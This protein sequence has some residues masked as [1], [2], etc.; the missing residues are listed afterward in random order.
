M[1]QHKYNLPSKNYRSRSLE[2]ASA[3]LDVEPLFC[4]F[5]STDTATYALS[6]WRYFVG[7]YTLPPSPSPYL[8]VHLGGKP[9]CRV[10]SNQDLLKTEHSIPGNLFTVAKNEQSTWMVNGEIDVFVLSAAEVVATDNGEEKPE[11][12]LW[13]LPLFKQHRV[14]LN[15]HLTSCILRQLLNHIESKDNTSQDYVKILLEMIE[16]HLAQLDLGL[17]PRPQLP[18][19]E[20]S[21]AKRINAAVQYLCEHLATELNINTL[22]RVAGINPLYFSELFKQHQGVTPQRFILQKRIDRARELLAATDLS[23]AVI[24]Q[25]TGFSSQGHLT[26]TFSRLME[27]TP[28]EF[29][30][31]VAS[32]SEIRNLKQRS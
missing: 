13:N 11:P 27:M 2:I 5:F 10:S 1:E 26:T 32:V 9:I 3:V 23:I 24:S 22:S 31:R 16:L 17:E 18:L 7:S 12:T 15:D 14:G 25:E 21:T 29:R 4:H 19:D 30:K 20:N 6:R 8:V 28:S